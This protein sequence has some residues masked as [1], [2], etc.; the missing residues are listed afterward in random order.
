MNY[1]Y[2]QNVQYKEGL[3]IIIHF[4]VKNYGMSLLTVSDNII[5]FAILIGIIKPFSKSMGAIAPL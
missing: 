3:T 5:T 1:F 4:T 2:I